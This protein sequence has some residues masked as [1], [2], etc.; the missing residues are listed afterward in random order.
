MAFIPFRWDGAVRKFPVAENLDLVNSTFVPSTACSECSSVPAARPNFPRQPVFDIQPRCP[1]IP[2]PYPTPT[3]RPTK[4]EYHECTDDRPASAPMSLVTP[5]TL[6][7]FSRPPLLPPQRDLPRS[8][9]AITPG[10]LSTT[11]A[12]K[13]EPTTE[14]PL[15]RSESP[16]RA[17][18]RLATPSDPDPLRSDG[19]PLA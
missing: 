12:V 1:N 11:E 16:R 7:S 13:P 15:A 5:F 17:L 8:Q 14:P 2:I 18:P 4:N 9:N 10:R 3:S 19:P 6:T